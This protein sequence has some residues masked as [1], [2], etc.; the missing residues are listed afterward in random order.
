MTFSFQST[1]YSPSLSCYAIN[2]IHCLSVPTLKA[3]SQILS[4]DFQTLQISEPPSSKTLMKLLKKVFPYSNWGSV[5]SQ[6]GVMR[7]E[8]EGYL[9][10]RGTWVNLWLIHIDVWQKPTQYCKAIILQLKISKFFFKCSLLV[11]LPNYGYNL[12]LPSYSGSRAIT[13]ESLVQVSP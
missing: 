7:R 1:S 9:S 2:F 6:T 8:G 13:L 3:I 10:G 5:T 4:P 12:Y 11:Q